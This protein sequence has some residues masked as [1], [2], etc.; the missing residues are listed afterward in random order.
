[1]NEIDT[2]ILEMYFRDGMKEHEIAKSLGL[3]ELLV[4]ETLADFENTYSTDEEQDDHE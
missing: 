3:S 1:M 4:H 2:Q